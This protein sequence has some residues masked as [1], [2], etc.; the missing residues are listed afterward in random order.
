MAIVRGKDDAYWWQVHHKVPVDDG[1]Y[2]AVSLKAKFKRLDKA[3]V[4]Q[5][6]DAITNGDASLSDEDLVREVLL[7][8]KQVRG[9]ELEDGSEPSF[10]VDDQRE[11]V[12]GIIGMEA[13]IVRAW[14]ESVT[15]GRL[16]N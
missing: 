13:A 14:A 5:V 12:L 10:A 3:R 9:L 2:A 8:W 11:W 7:D 6:L 15:G 16:K 1:R 4:G